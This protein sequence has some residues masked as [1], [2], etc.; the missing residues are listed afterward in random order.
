MKSRLRE[1]DLNLL[2]VLEALIRKKSV[3]RAAEDLEMS[4]SAVSHA[5]KRLR[6]LFEDELFVRSREGMSPTPKVVE[7][8]GYVNEIVRLAGVTMLPSQSFDPETSDRTVTLALGDA[9]DM[10]ILPILAKYVRQKGGN[11]RIV[12]IQTTAEE[13]LPLLE[14]GRLDIYVGVM[15]AESTDLLCQKLYE[16]QLVVIASQMHRVRKTI[17]F[18]QYAELEHIVVQ[19]RTK[20]A[21]ISVTQD[22]FDKS[23]IKR[24]IR[25]E[26]PHLAAVPMI[27]EKDHQLIST[28]PLSLAQYYRRSAKIKIIEPDFFLPKIEVSQYWHRRYTN[29]PFTLW[30]RQTMRELFQNKELAYN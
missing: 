20:S 25:V 18:A 1:L 28:V 26:T 15:N 12:S 22:L 6:D 19:P 17:S 4:Q 11:T 3:S 7:I 9:G 14:T 13:A 21:K 16:D 29:D 2:V 27:L 23:G 8:A 5:L 10:A 30:I 24:S